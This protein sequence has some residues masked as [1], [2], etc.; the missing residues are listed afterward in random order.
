MI[1]KNVLRAHG[2]LALV[3]FA[4]SALLV[5]YAIHGSMPTNPIKLPYEADAHTSL[6]A[7]E[8]WKFFTRDP[9]EDRADALV[10]A[11][12]GVW[13]AGL[14]GPNARAD[15][16][17]GLDRGGRAQGVELGLLLQSVAKDAFE[18]CEDAPTRCLDAHETRLHLV[19]RSPRP[20]LCG[21]V[22]FVLQRPVPW[23]WSR[24]RPIMPSRVAR[25]E[26]SC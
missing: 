2:A 18:E 12:G 9:Q 21:D 13:E 22:G 8:G 7:P 25:V 20:T 16:A 6:W 15:H 19:N 24:S 26:V 14:H 4:G 3:L 1:P 23:A 10:R 5:V 17:F 11:V